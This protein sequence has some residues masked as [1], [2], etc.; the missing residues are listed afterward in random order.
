MAAKKGPVKK[1]VEAVKDATKTVAKA[2][3]KKVVK[4]VAKPWNGRSLR[5]MVGLAFVVTGAGWLPGATA[6]PALEL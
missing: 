5:P 4:P 3:K 1:A 6:I 2:A